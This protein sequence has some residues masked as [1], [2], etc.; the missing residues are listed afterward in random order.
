MSAIVAGELV[1]ALDAA[2]FVIMRKPPLEAHGG[3]L[4]PAREPCASSDQT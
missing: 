3:H 4:G 2:G 1:D